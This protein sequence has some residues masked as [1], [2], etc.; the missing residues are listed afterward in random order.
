MEKK[1]Y[2]VEEFLSRPQRL[3]EEIRKQRDHIAS[4]QSIVERRTTRLSF[5]AGRNPSKNEKAFED[6]MIQI[7]EEKDKLDLLEK[8]LVKAETEVENFIRM[9]P[10]AN[11][12][13]LL[14]ARFVKGMSMTDIRENM[15]LGRT[16]SYKLYYAA[17]GAASNLFQK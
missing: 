5:T 11:Q 14:R 15:M 2:G 16:N 8:Q 4:L 7:A 6:V 1:T 10:D 9:S 3:E 12:Q 13:T 17:M